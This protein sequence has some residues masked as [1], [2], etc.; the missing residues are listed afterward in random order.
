ME[1]GDAR[2]FVHSGWTAVPEGGYLVA[3]GGAKLIGNTFS[4]R[5]AQQ[6]KS[7][8]NASLNVIETR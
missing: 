8:P 2:A 6:V 4:R 1:Q 3:C 7:A 5:Y